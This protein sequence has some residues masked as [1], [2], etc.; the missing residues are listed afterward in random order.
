MTN[1]FIKSVIQELCS[2]IVTG[3]I[4]ILG[5]YIKTFLKQHISELQYQKDC[6]IAKRIVLKVEEL[7]NEFDW[8]KE[9]KHAKATQMISSRTGLSSDDIFD[10][11][12]STVTEIKLSL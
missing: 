7:A 2:V 1:E 4:G 10:I 12:K 9:V 8:E 6:A 11:I 3:I 5:Y